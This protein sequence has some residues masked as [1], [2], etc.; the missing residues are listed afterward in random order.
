MKRETIT[1]KTP[2]GYEI[3]LKQWLT[4][5][6]RQAINSKILGDKNIDTKSG[7][8]KLQKETLFE[9]Q[10]ESIRQYVNSVKDLDGK[11]IEEDLLEYL[12]DLKETDFNFVNDEISKLTKK[13]SS[14]LKK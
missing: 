11:N 5:R 4:G 14:E 7:E 9:L 3:E 10:N 1:I 13:E 8:I 2:S 12:L 6:E